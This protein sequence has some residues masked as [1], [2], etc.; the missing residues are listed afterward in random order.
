[1]WIA[2]GTLLEQLMRE[3]L[4]SDTCPVTAAI[5]RTI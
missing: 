4:E 5:I 2:S 1:V 3:R